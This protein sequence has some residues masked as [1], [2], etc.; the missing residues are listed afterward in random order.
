M[1]ID[2]TKMSSRGQVV[3]PIE[4]RK[5]INEGDKLIIIKRDNEII[6]KKSLPETALWSEKSLAKTWLT[7]EEDEAWKDL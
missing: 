4:M 2:T 1:Q 6:L 7:K 5:G 3:I